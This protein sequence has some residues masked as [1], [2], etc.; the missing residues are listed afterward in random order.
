MVTSYD[1]HLYT[2]YNDGN[3]N[4]D[5]NNDDHNDII[6]IRI[7]ITMKMMVIDHVNNENDGY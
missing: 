4:D 5:N 2:Y 7:T 3:D 6:M 1:D